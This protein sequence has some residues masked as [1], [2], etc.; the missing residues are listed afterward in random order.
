M[1]VFISF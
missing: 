1:M